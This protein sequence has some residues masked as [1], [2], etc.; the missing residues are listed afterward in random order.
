M[1]TRIMKFYLVLRECAKITPRWGGDRLW[2]TIGEDENLGD[3]TFW[4]GMEGCKKI[5]FVFG[6]RDYKFTWMTGKLGGGGG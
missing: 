6:G 4:L 1:F 5:S 2:K 3:M